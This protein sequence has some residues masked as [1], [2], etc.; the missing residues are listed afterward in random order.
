VTEDLVVQGAE[1]APTTLFAAAFVAAQAEM[2]AVEPDS[3]NPHF[4]NQFVS[5]DHL[6]AKT[7]P[8]LNRHGFAVAQMLATSDTGAPVLRTILIHGPSGEQIRADAPLLIAKNDMQA[9]GSAITYARRYAWAAALGIV[10]DADNDGNGAAPTV[11]MS[12]PAIP[13]GDDAA[14]QLMPPAEKMIST[15]QRTRL[16]TIA[17]NNNVDETRLRAIVLE[18]TGQESTKN[19]PAGA[20]YDAV[21]AQV[22]AAGAA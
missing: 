13:F 8:V 1:L 15:A 4:G 7:R 22:E 3:T 19:I 16:F 21:V 17:C 9:L 14:P 5:L 6:I 18:H 20:V 2:P 11:D 12:D 10:A